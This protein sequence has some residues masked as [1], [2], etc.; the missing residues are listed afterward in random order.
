[1]FRLVAVAYMNEGVSPG[2]LVAS[3]MRIIWDLMK[4]QDMGDMQ[5][6]N[7]LYALVDGVREQG[8][9]KTTQNH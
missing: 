3:L 1:L 4:A 6:S 5:I 9:Q 8:Y 2:T 7:E